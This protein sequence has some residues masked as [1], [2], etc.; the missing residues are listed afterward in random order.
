[1]KKGKRMKKKVLIVITI[2]AGIIILFSSMNRYKRIKGVSVYNKNGQ[3]H[4]KTEYVH[5]KRE[6]EMKSFYDDGS[7]KYIGIYKD[8]SVVEGIGWL[9]TG[10]KRIEVT[11]KKVV[12]YKASGE[13]YNIVDKKEKIVKFYEGDRVTEIRGRQLFESEIGSRKYYTYDKDLNYINKIYRVF[14]IPE[15]MK[16]FKFS[17]LTDEDLMEVKYFDEAGFLD[18]ISYNSENKI[19]KCYRD[20]RNNV[21]KEEV[22][23]GPME[24]LDMEEYAQKKLYEDEEDI[25][26]VEQVKEYEYNEKD[27]LVREKSMVVREGWYNWDLSYI[28]DEKGRLITEKYNRSKEYIEQFYKD[29]K[30]MKEIFHFQDGN[31]EVK[32]KKIDK[33][34]RAIE[35]KT[36]LDFANRINIWKYKFYKDTNMYTKKEYIK[37][38]DG[39]ESRTYTLLE[40]EYDE[41]GRNIKLKYR[42]TVKDPMKEYEYKY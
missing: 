10:E 33:L 13:I 3:L 12:D 30:W 6:G 32:T 18:K 23:K 41:K 39:I 14:R 27:K 26:Y 25:Y 42:D 5:G 15:K 11:P 19:K 7:K 34:G 4:K 38:I 40:A 9:Q 20:N 1:M 35:Q 29:D 24:L 37:I 8:D 36:V 16:N 22:L 2:L 21:I 17:D 28:Y 31:V